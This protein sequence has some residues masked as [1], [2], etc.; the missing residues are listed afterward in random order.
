MA[1]D[2]QALLAPIPGGN[3]SG[4][5]LRYHALTDQIK[6][7]RRR[8]E[9]VEQGVWKREVKVADY[10]A[11]IKLSTQAL[12][13]HGKDLQIVAWLTEALTA[14][15]GFRGLRQGLELAHGLLE[16]YWDTVHPE[17]DEDG[18]LEMRATPLRWIGRQLEPIVRE[19]P[20]TES[21]LGLLQYL[22]S[23]TVPTE[24]EAKSNS[25]KA[26]V[27]QEAIADGKTTPEDWEQAVKR[28]PVEFLAEIKAEIEE[29]NSYLADFGAFCDE[30]F[31]DASP[32]FGPLKKVL[33]EIGQTVHVLHVQRS[34]QAKAAAP[35]KQAAPPPAEPA[36]AAAPAPSLSSADLGGAM[37][38][39]AADLGISLD[40]FDTS[41]DWGEQTEET[42]EPEAEPEP[43]LTF[44]DPAA[45]TLQMD[46]QPVLNAAPTLVTTPAAA[47]APAG[48]MTMAPVLDSRD[49][50]IRQIVEAA[51]YLRQEEPS[52][53][54]PYLV[55]RALRFG[56]LRDDG[57]EPAPLTLA[58][59]ETA[60]R[61]DLKRLT[62]EGAPEEVLEASERAMG[63]E[64]GRAWL[65]LQRVSITALEQ[66]GYRLAARAVR[67]ALSNLLA[68]YPELPDATLADDTP[69]ANRDTREWLE[70]E[71]I[72]GDAPRPEPLPPEEPPD[73][74]DLA[75]HAARAGRVEEAVGI[76][77]R[78]IAQ[79][80]SGRGRFLRKVQLAEICAGTGHDGIAFP[81]LEDLAAEIESRS[82]E[83]WEPAETIT[84]P[85]ALLYSCIDR[86]TK[87]ETRKAA[88]YA[89]I[90][91]LDPVR[92]LSLRR[93]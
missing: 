3:P 93:S 43:V 66:L 29:L 90:C 54:V 55:L 60:R 17:I 38:L 85:L 18:D 77:S 41:T 11:V 39:S 5:D 28:T 52:S 62:L 30:K 35:A 10:G 74:Y 75:L 37:V 12:T 50:A 27:R 34:S 49:A 24:A 78:E 58:P 88:L 25:S 83:G 46:P 4:Q 6:E 23:K 47:P 67:Q 79:E 81:I 2:V 92:G 73:A 91:R 76:M 20:F 51:H 64:C 14:T 65:D 61:V 89:R 87:D 48:R 44:A 1:V 36:P 13:K 32:E 69:A 8:E 7:A 70:A 22:E 33:E 53:T 15:E 84:Q 82:L 31:G 59:P 86:I 16:Q 57:A 19:V 68:E 45:L 71:G 40:E 9:D 72:P 63:E 26:P 80:T 21:G 56:E 42:A